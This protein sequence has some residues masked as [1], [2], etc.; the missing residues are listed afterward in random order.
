[1][2]IKW[3]SY[4]GG[5]E[6]T[7]NLPIIFYD[8]VTFSK[9]TTVTFVWVESANYFYELHFFCENGDQT[10]AG[11]GEEL[12]RAYKYLPAQQSVGYNIIHPLPFLLLVPGL[13]YV[14]NGQ[15]SAAS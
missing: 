11:G 10:E 14:Q 2:K 1:M 15:I 7:L 9:L 3:R 12:Y 13:P 4:L 6:C 5:I 8:D